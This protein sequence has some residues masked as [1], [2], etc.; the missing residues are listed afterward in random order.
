MF[1]CLIFSEDDANIS[2]MYDAGMRDFPEFQG[3]NVQ[4]ECPGPAHGWLDFAKLS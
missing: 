4:T 2:K 1:H 3:P